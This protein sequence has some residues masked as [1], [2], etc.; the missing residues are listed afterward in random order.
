MGIKSF[1]AFEWNW[2]GRR[3]AGTPLMGDIKELHPPSIT[4]ARQAQAI[5]GIDGDR[6]EAGVVSPQAGIF[7]V[8]LCEVIAILS[9][10]WR[11]IC[12]W[13]GSVDPLPSLS[14][15]RPAAW[16]SG[17]ERETKATCSGL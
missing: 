6:T 15:F 9:R 17:A 13:A 11:F 3:W 5:Q 7:R 14:S 8:V 12:L 1:F 4:V 10:S 2:G 16:A